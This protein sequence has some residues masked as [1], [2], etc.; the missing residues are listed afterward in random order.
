MHLSTENSCFPCSFLSY[1]YVGIGY[2]CGCELQVGVYFNGKQRC[3]VYCLNV[4][5]REFVMRVSKIDRA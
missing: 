1:I 4:R 2:A 5:G 3:C